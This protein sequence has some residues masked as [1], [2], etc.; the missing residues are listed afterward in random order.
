MV[1]DFV[2]YGHRLGCQDKDLFPAQRM[3]LN[4][5]VASHKG[6]VKAKSMRNKLAALLWFHK[7]HDLPWNAT[8]KTY[9][10]C[11]SLDASAP[12]S[13]WKERREPVTLEMIRLL[14]QDLTDSPK[15]IAVMAIAAC[16]FF[17]MLRL[18][19]PLPT[20]LTGEMATFHPRWSNVSFDWKKKVVSVF[21][22]WTK[23]KQRI[24]ETVHIA[25]QS[26]VDPF[27][28]LE[29]HWEVSGNRLGVESFLYQFR[30]RLGQVMALDKTEFMK[31]CNEIW[32]AHGYQRFTGHSFRIG[33]TTAF[34]ANG[35]DPKVVQSLGRWSS[36][37]FMKYWRKEEVI[38]L[39]QTANRVV[40]DE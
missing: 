33:G 39:K 6:L 5:W 13:S 29:R 9:M 38:C 22:P 28:L 4:M 21:L 34:L 10:L 23:T 17:G 18:G 2:D 19:E 7:S 31:R 36:D 1:G 16:A 20:S 25:S 24:G 26:V 14:K 15:D 40:S 37:A 35:I 27:E 8:D 32:A 12:D 3:M 30:T 11:K